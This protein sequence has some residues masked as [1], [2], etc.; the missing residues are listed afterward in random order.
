VLYFLIMVQKILKLSKN[1]FINRV[2]DRIA[3]VII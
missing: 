3:Q 1:Y 2:H